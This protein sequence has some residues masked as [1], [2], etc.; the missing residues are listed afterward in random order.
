MDTQ[1]V[2][3]GAVVLLVILVLM[4]SKVSVETVTAGQPRI[5]CPK[6]YTYSMENLGCVPSVESSLRRP[7]V[8][9]GLN[10]EG[11]SCR[12]REARYSGN[13]L[14]ENTSHMQTYEN[15]F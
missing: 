5:T 3:I 9:G 15:L 11:M 12:D 1:K 2:L 8:W 4:K 14:V 7:G 10:S 6:G 13:E